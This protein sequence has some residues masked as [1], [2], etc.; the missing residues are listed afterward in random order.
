M[1]ENVVHWVCGLGILIAALVPL[2]WVLVQKYKGSRD[3]IQQEV[4]M[5]SADQES[6]DRMWRVAK[7]LL[8]NMTTSYNRLKVLS[9]RQTLTHEVHLVGRRRTDPRSTVLV[10]LRVAFDQYG[11]P[12]YFFKLDE[13]GKASVS[14]YPFCKIGMM[15]RV[16]E[17]LLLNP[18]F[19]TNP[20]VGIEREVCMGP[21]HASTLYHG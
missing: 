20:A 19:S 16:I 1:N 17:G 12:S 15:Q 21:E 4:V 2:I 8:C 3:S 6:L 11:Q 13:G 18:A 7:D 5:L 10:R 14:V 9:D